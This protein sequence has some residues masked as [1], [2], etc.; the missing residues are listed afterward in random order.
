[1]QK[2]EKIN[3]VALR[4]AFKVTYIYE[5]YFSFHI[6]GR[7]VTVMQ[8]QAR[9]DIHTSGQVDPKS[10]S[11]INTEYRVDKTLYQVKSVFT[12]NQKAE[13][14]EDKIK[15]LILEDRNSKQLAM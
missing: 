10:K 14:L 7:R 1:L 3:A 13:P 5:R 8:S 12:G 6:Y 11:K 15:R 2:K 4:F 9:S